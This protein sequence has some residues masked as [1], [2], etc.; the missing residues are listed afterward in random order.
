[1]AGRGGG[2]RT[3]ERGYRRLKSQ[4][5]SVRIRLITSDVPSGM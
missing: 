1:M 2:L 3:L 4:R 5:R